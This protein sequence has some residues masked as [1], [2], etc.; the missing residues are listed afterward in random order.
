MDWHRSSKRRQTLENFKYWPLYVVSMPYKNKKDKLAYQRKWYRENKDKQI[1]WVLAG[2]RRIRAWFAEYKK[3][4]ACEKC[5]ENH[6]A[7]IVFHHTNVDNKLDNVANLVSKGD[8][9]R[10]ILEEISKCQC[11][12]ANCHRKVH[13]EDNR[14]NAG[15]NPVGR[16]RTCSSVD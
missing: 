6:P 2:K 12:C 11:L 8:S 3:D 13:S 1:G 15:S 9:K 4:F 5:G 14:K 7:C 16:L 10:L